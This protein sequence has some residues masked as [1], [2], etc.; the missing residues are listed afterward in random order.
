MSEDVLEQK[1]EEL[2]K[3]GEDHAKAKGQLSL[4]D[5]NRKILLATLMKDHMISSNTGKL[6]SVNAQEREA[7]ADPKYQNHIKALAI[8][9]E[10]ESKLNWEKKLVDMN[11]EAWKTK[12][13]SQM[14]EYKKYGNK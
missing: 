13:I 2:R 12:T 10:N 3:L 4:L 7:R 5:N 8:A 9:I 1:M 11:F 6:E 14:K